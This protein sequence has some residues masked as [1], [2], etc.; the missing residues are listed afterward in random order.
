MWNK[1]FLYGFQNAQFE[2]TVLKKTKLYGLTEET[3]MGFHKKKKKKR[4]VITLGLFLNS[5]G[6]I[7][8]TT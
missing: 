8:T 7:L 2:E 4:P 1:A 3:D 6:N 5:H